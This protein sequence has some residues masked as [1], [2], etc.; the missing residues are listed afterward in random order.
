MFFLRLRCFLRILII[1]YLSSNI[2]VKTLYIKRYIS[3]S[4]TSNILV[5]LMLNNPTSSYCNRR[6]RYL[7]SI[8]FIVDIVKLLKCL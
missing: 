5:L 6:Y 1:I 4:F 7:S 2:T 3:I 8:A